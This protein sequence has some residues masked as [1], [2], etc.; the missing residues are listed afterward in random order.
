M[1]TDIFWKWYEDWNNNR[2]KIEL[3]ASKFKILKLNNSIYYEANY[4]ILVKIFSWSFKV[5]IKNNKKNCL[6]AYLDIISQ[7]RC[8]IFRITDRLKLLLAKAV[9]S[10]AEVPFEFVC[11]VFG[12]SSASV[13]L[14]VRCSHSIS[15]SFESSA[16]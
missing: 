11:P 6:T 2:L 14:W 8:A 13:V 4:I 12:V 7:N 16:A 15:R 9:A 1:F 3:M 10:R 5:A